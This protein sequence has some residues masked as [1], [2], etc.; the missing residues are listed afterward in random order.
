MNLYLFCDHIFVSEILS[1]F[2][3]IDLLV[4]KLVCKKFKRLV[5]NYKKKNENEFYI[6]EQ[7]RLIE[8]GCNLVKIEKF[9]VICLFQNKISF[10]CEVFMKQIRN[11]SYLRTICEMNEELIISILD[12]LAN[13]YL[14]IEDFYEDSFEIN[15]FEYDLINEQSLLLTAKIG[16]ESFEFDLIKVFSYIDD[17]LAL[18]DI[19]PY[20]EPMNIL[21]PKNEFHLDK[22]P[23]PLKLIHF[24]PEKFRNFN[25]SISRYFYSKREQVDDIDGSDTYSDTYFDSDFDSDYD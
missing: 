5:I 8:N 12:L 1:K 10:W 18:E 7:K 21:F 11:Y 14:T 20:I 3:N 24:I 15:D 9:E 23:N 2:D 4:F 19:Y 16:D 17:F 13:E 6:K 22:T 25:F